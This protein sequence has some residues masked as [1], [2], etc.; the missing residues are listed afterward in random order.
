MLE[1]VH[2]L[3]RGLG[4]VND[5]LLAGLQVDSLGVDLHT[6]GLGLSLLGVVLAHSSLE[7]LAA[8]RSADMLNSDVNSL[9][10]DSASVL[11]VDDDTD[12]VLGHIENTTGLT[13]VELVRHAL[14]NGAVSDNID[15]V[16]LL[17]S[18]HDL[19]KMDGAVLSEGLGEKVS[20]SSSVSVGVGHLYFLIV[21]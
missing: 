12:G 15:E 16:T 21:K 2:E 9:G 8:L 11:L 4:D 13:V 7:G 14:V 17:V 5:V 6:L 1:G 20:G 19:G 18:L 3:D 10:D